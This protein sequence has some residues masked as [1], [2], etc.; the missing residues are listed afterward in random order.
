M[1]DDKKKISQQTSRETERG[2]INSS[3]QSAANTGNLKIDDPAKTSHEMADANAHGAG[4]VRK[5]SYPRNEV[6]D[7]PDAANDRKRALEDNPN[8]RSGK[9][10]RCADVGVENCNWSVTG[11]HEDEIVGRVREHARDQHHLE[12]KE[13]DKMADKVRGAIRDRA[14]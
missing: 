13:F 5:T 4:D 6:S 14:A 2:T 10:F 12:E 8:N 1:S 9:S 7:N 3:V 11:T